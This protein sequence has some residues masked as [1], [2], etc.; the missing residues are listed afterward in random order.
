[1]IDPVTGRI[2]TVEQDD[3][4][5]GEHS[6]NERNFICRKPSSRTS[7]GSNN[8]LATNPRVPIAAS[9]MIPAPFI[10]SPAAISDFVLNRH[11]L[12]QQFLLSQV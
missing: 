1:M 2:H 8:S 6:A 11:Q 12:I 4:K 10:G 9:A 3:Q 7:D 5:F